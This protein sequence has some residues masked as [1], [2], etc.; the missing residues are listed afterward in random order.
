VSRPRV[1]ILSFAPLAIDARVLRQAEYLAE[2]F[3]VTAI[4]LPPR[5]ASHAG[6]E[7]VELPR[8]ESR[9][10]DVAAVAALAAGRIVPPAY[11]FWIGAR[12]AR[13]A[14]RALLRERAFDAIV[15][16]EWPALLVALDAADPRRVVFDAHEFSPEEL[17]DAAFRLLRAPL[18]RRVLRRA[19]AAGITGTTVSAEIAGRFAREFGLELT[20]VLSAPRLVELPPQQPASPHR[21][22]LVHHGA[23]MRERRL[24]TMLHAVAQAGSRFELTMM[25]VGDPA[26]VADLRAL[27]A[28]LAGDR[29]RFVDPVPPGEIVR[30]LAA[31]DLGIFVLDTAIPNYAMALPNKFFDFI[32]AGL[33]IVIGPSPS[34]AALGQAHGVVHVA[35]GFDAPAVAS[36]LAALTV[37]RI[38]EMKRAARVARL[39]LNADA[40]MRKL[41]AIVRRRLA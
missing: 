37:D 29:I 23:A 33:G 13:R 28:R 15:A 2:H 35:D 31:Y 38:E 24:E 22:R 4:T 36:A 1:G 18:V 34:M 19:S 41:V 21:V 39:A 14:A 20:P 6:F 12:P 9:L 27:G 3:E 26:Y 8:H 5:P 7:V 25:L 11:G 32:G 16:N 30:A 17:T 10:G 40:E